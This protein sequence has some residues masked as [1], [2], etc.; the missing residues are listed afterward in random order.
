M[1]SLAAPPDEHKATLAGV[2]ETFLYHCGAPLMEPSHPLHGN[3]CV[4]QSIRCR[5]PVQF[6]YYSKVLPRSETPFYCFLCARNMHLSVPL[7]YRSRYRD[8]LPL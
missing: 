7:E 3:V 4:V 8:V 2:K 5:D 1:F 6:G